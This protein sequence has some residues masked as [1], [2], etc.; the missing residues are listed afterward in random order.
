MTEAKIFVD[1]YTLAED[2]ASE[3]EAFESIAVPLAWP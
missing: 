1:L 2:F 3:K